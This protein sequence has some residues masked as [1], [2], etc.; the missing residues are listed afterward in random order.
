MSQSGVGVAESNTLNVIRV[1]PNPSNGYFA[2][3]LSANEQVIISNTLGQVVLNKNFDKILQ[4]IDIQNNING[5][6]FVKVIIEGK[7]KVV[8]LVK[9]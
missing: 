3:E 9:Q 2:I 8:K 4:Y 1:Y 6:Y 5:I 7:E